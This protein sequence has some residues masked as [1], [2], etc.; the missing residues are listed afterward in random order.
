MDMCTLLPPLAA[1]LL[2]ETTAVPFEVENPVGK[3][4]AQGKRKA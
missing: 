2:E 4:A 3:E 1:T